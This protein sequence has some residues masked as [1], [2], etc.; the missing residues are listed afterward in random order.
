[1]A[2][3]FPPAAAPRAPSA[4]RG[5]FACGALMGLLTV[6]AAALAAHLPP[7]LLA[8][9][10]R[11]ALQA[12]VQILGWHAGAI[13]AAA[14]WMREAGRPVLVHLAAAGFL[15]G[16]A[17]FVIGVAVPALRGPHLGRLAPTGGTALMLAWA[18]LALSAWP[19]HRE[20]YHQ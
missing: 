16:S 17:C 15:L 19:R 1:M 14:L 9:G 8:G 11:A 6:A 4:S 7:R 13:L 2:E 18:L 10:G 12:A 20:G 5:W 3:P